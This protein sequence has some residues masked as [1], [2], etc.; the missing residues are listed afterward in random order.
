M[1]TLLPA[2]YI[3][4][5]PFGSVDSR[6]ALPRSVA[7]AAANNI[8][9]LIDIVRWGTQEGLQENEL[10][11]SHIVGLRSLRGLRGLRSGQRDTRATR[12]R[13]LVK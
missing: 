3:N 8:S 7:G 12:Q 6:L 4:K 11:E 2:G 5:V 10:L 13:T 9:S 1:T